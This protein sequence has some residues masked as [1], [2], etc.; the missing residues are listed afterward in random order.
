VL[1]FDKADALFGKRTEV[2]DSHDCNAHIEVNYLRQRVEEYRGL[3][4][5]SPRTSA[6]VRRRRTAPARDMQNLRG[7]R[8]RE[9]GLGQ[10]LP[11]RRNPDESAGW[12]SLPIVQARRLWQQ[13]RRRRSGGQR[14]IAPASR[15]RS[16][17]DRS[18]LEHIFE[19]RS[20]ECSDLEAR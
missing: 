14:A 10:A 6:P 19:Q 12:R 8:L 1:L 9:R 11:R 2:K 13:A 17:A 16:W 3:S 7:V 20:V 15:S 18:K 5:P 4:I